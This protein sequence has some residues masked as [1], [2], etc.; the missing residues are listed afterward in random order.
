MLKQTF[1]IVTYKIK[2]FLHKFMVDVN[3]CACAFLVF[4]NVYFLTCLVKKVTH[5][6]LL[7]LFLIFL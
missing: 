7:I 3:A 5:I 6:F 2:M 1:E 4:R